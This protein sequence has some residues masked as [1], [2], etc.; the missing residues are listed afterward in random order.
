MYK[1]SGFLVCIVSAL[2]FI[3]F[4]TTNQLTQQIAYA[5]DNKEVY[6]GGMPA[7]F[8]IN[9]GGVQVV[10]I[11]DV[12][13]ES[14]TKSPAGTAGIKVGD[15][16]VKM[17]GVPIETISDLNTILEK[18][19]IKA[20]KV[21]VKRGASDEIFEITPLKDKNSGKF[22]IGV[23]VKDTLSGIG[24]VTYIEKES[25]RFGSLGHAV[26]GEMKTCSNAESGNMY[27]C[28]I[29]NILKGV[30][31]RAGELHGM[32]LGSQIIG[33]TDTV[34]DC[35]I[36]GEFNSE[37][38]LSGFS[39]AMACSSS[40]M[41]G[42]AII[43]STINGQKPEKFAIEIVKVDKNNK[44]NKN[45]VVKITDEELIGKTGGIVQGMS[46]SPILQNGVLVGAITHV[47][48]NDPTR[49]YGISI[50][51]MLNH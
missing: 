47:F 31:G 27:G 51:K 25:K 35:G 7:G 15:K 10:G 14:E 39:T 12:I 3:S 1:F 43:Y 19:G 32:F 5:N 28:S 36:Y 34:C 9:A 37:F 29:I 48:L 6:I 33:K 49:G 21:Q 8:T 23:L 44:E 40:V 17:A 45:Y 4:N 13:G 30:R 41:P 46:G 42:D 24:T 2:T 26:G 38:D 11:C 20:L 22:K 18:N 16:I 50:E